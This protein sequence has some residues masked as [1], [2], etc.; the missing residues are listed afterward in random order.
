MP[1]L[2]EAEARRKAMRRSK[3]VFGR[4]ASRYRANGFMGTLPLPPGQKQ[5]PPTGFT[6]G[7]RPHPDD[8]QVASWIREQPR[9]NIALRLAEVP[10]EFLDGRGDLPFKYADNNVDGWELVGI[11]VDNYKK[12][13]SEKRGA[14]QLRELEAELGQ[15]PA[16]ALSGARLDTGS[17][18]AVYLV[19][20]GYRFA[21]KAAE[22]I[23][24]AQKRHRYMMVHPSTNPD[25]IGPDG[26]PAMYEWGLG[27][28]SKLAD[29]GAES[30]ERFQDGMP[31]LNQV[32]VLPEAWFSH[33][34]H[35]GMGESD[36][37][38]SGLTDGQLREWLEVRPGYGDEMCSEMK[39]AV[40]EWVAKIEASS[41][42]HD[43][44]RDAHWRLVKLASEGHAGVK[45]ALDEVMG[46]AWP[47]AVGKRDVET[48]NAEV[49]RSMA[50]A[51]DKI[52]PLWRM[53]NGEDYAPDDTC[54]VRA[55][56][57]A[58][59]FDCDAW[60]EKARRAPERTG[61]FCL[62]SARELAEPVEPIRWLVRGIWP[63]RSAGVL[64]GDKKSLKTWNLQALALAVAAGRPLF[65][66]YHVVSPGPVL[67]LSGEG[68][69]NT[70]ANRHQVIAKRYGIT[71]ML[72]ELAFGAEFGVGML[73]DDEFTD[74][75][76]RHLDE[77]QPK[78]V[79]L[80]PLYAYHPNS[81]EVQNVYARGPML[82]NLRELIGGQAALIVGDHFNKTA[83]GRLDLDNIAQAGM[84]QWADSWIL[85]KHRE[86]PNLEEN[87]FWLEMETGSRR[88][89]GKHLE[90]DW[91]LERDQSDPDVMAWSGVDWDTRPM[92]A[93]SA[94]GKV[95]D[96]VA[97]ILQVVT[98][99]PFELTESAVLAEVGGNRAKAREA[100]AG[101]KANGGVVV[102]KAP[103]QEA[104]GTKT[105]D[106]VGLGEN[107]ERLRGKRF[108]R[109]E[110][111]EGSESPGSTDTED[112]T[113]S[114]Q[115]DP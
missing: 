14:D 115:V 102:K 19:P 85:Q 46:A 87:K 49:G 60:A 72:S 108:R 35:G 91:T 69:R 22:S 88:G 92:A 5:S 59:E 55:R 33:L 34:T 74:A 28:P 109:E 106:L 23:D 17:C 15:L 70:F 82:A 66:K 44:L 43:V 47:A 80:D 79:I 27:A 7:G 77:L 56:V 107:A 1:S 83:P 62:V 29:A 10:R 16:T 51:L 100:F 111:R 53:G 112:G 8:E 99:H 58:G 50:G 98:D 37:P 36:D 31:T 103:R 32:A 40:D 24:I 90:L 2:P 86:T 94:G 21:G 6:G 39:T 52:Q 25:A 11:D 76:K 18:I 105:R 96:T 20:K 41:S 95:D 71:D 26:Q 61:R 67:Y 93:K 101:L 38:I 75:I 42:T 65:D 97:A 4:A 3:S 78:L 48:L 84:A 113:G 12:G 45:A 13:E 89:G 64:A 68:G 54:R 104:G 30:L 81:V 57:E 9:G 114:E 73:D 110:L 63:E